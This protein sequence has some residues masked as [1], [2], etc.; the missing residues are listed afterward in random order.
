MQDNTIM[1][2]LLL[3]VLTSEFT[4]IRSEYLNVTSQVLT[5]QKQDERNL[6]RNLRTLAPGSSLG[7]GPMDLNQ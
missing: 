4:G 3:N 7:V 6:W 1:E 5:N 2:A